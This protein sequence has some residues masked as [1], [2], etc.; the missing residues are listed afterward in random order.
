MTLSSLLWIGTKT[1]NSN[2]TRLKPLICAVMHL[3]VKWLRKHLKCMRQ[4]LLSYSSQLGTLPNVHTTYNSASFGQSKAASVT[5]SEWKQQSK[6]LYTAVWIV[7]WTEY[8]IRELNTA[9]AI[10]L[11]TYVKN[12]WNYFC[13]KATHSAFALVSPCTLTMTLMTLYGVHE[14]ECQFRLL[15]CSLHNSHQ[16]LYFLYFINRVS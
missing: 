13:T 1:G 15:G 8:E 5:M 16:E 9:E 11:S 6:E 14:V 3:L 7:L 4:S 10:S 2:I 12:K